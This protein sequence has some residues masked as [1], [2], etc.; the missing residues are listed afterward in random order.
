MTKNNLKS[1]CLIQILLPICLA[2]VSFIADAQGR[3]T[4]S[5]LS[6]LPKIPSREVEVA[7][8]DSEGYMWYG[9]NGIVGRDDGYNVFGFPLQDAD[10]VYEIAED[11]SGRIWIGTDKGC[12]IIDKATYE[13]K[14]FD[15]VRIGDAEVNLVRATSDGSMWLSTKGKLQRFDKN[16]KWGGRYILTDRYGNPTTVSGFTESRQ[17]DILIT[18]YSRGI[19]RYDVTGDRFVM[20]APIGINVS[21]G[22][23][24]QDHVND[25]Y[26]VSDHQGMVYRFDP[27]APAESKFKE[28]LDRNTDVIN[29]GRRVRTMDQDGVYGYLWIT[30]RSGIA[31][32]KP[33]ADGRLH[34]ISN[35]ATKEFEGAI[36]TSLS[37]ADDRIWVFCYD[38]PNTI[39]NIS[40]NSIENNRLEE[41]QTRYGDFPVIQEICPDPD[42]DLIWMIQLRSG[43]ILYNRATGVISDS[44]RP[45]LQG[46]RLHQ[47]DRIVPSG[48]LHGIWATQKGS[49]K[50]YGVSHDKAMNMQIADSITIAPLVSESAKITSLYESPHAKL[51]IGTTEGLFKYDLRN[52]R[53]EQRVKGLNGANGFLKVGKTLWVIDDTGLFAVVDGQRPERKSVSESFSTISP[54]PDGKLW[55]GTRSGRVMSYN[56]RDGYTKDYSSELQQKRGEIKQ[57][58][59]D[60]F[61]HVWIF[62]DQLVSQFNPRNR[63]HHDYEAGLKGRLNAY[64]S[65]RNF[66]TPDE[67]IVV[68]GIGGLA[69]FTP[70]NRLDV[71]NEEPESLVTE[72]RIDGRSSLNDYTEFFKDG[73]LVLP[74]DA[75]NIEIFFSTLDQANARNE[76]FAYRIKGVD[77]DW[78][79]TKMGENKAFYNNIPSGRWQLEVRACNENNLWSGK[80][81]E[82]Q[83][84]SKAPLYASW[85]AIIIY[86]AVVFGLLFYIFYMYSRHV[87]KENE[88]MWTD[89][90]EMVKMREYLQS[91]VTLP[92]EEFRELDR[93]LLEKA[94]K[95]VEANLSA[96]DF[97]VVDL[98]QGVNMSKSSLA[99]K[100]KA[101]T[102]KTPLDFIRQIKMKH[103][104]HLLESQNHTV[105]EVAD[106]VGFE[107]RRYF[108]TS[109]KKEVGVT[110][111][112]Y[113]KGERASTSSDTSESGDEIKSNANESVDSMN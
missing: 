13:V 26:W 85:W 108:T 7:M 112:A 97:G 95:V 30:T 78:N 70:S 96:P 104:C 29:P 39:L 88:K 100:L 65:T 58:Y 50:V 81:N 49:L 101:I 21:L 44:D 52:H 56:P 8:R 79:Y 113:V 24:I 11:Q 66:I 53:F 105:A 32:L 14:K 54:A 2:L 18:T 34:A 59:V 46:K 4:M 31:V 75:R 6:T 36:V 94:T 69:I 12:F 92:Q 41:V 99:R 9:C 91:P 42:S 5:P 10:K 23:I 40:E 111:S 98:A 106:M 1:V 45:D 110:P 25:F 86:V 38:K 83:I 47:T 73:R 61:G 20:Y 90:K 74:P 67:E 109:F 68:G 93:V 48:F 57:I 107:D 27:L 55:L 71:E 37:L 72:V 17:G 16:G 35:S 33:D 64:M 82:L 3:I 28:S 60:K 22:K 89:S 19:Y 80:V 102:G 62:S 103:A 84:N 51:W 87:N 76:R 77:K 43:L 15:D 63:S